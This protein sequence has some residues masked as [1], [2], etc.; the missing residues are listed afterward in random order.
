MFS[1]LFYLFF[2]NV[3]FGYKV[4]VDSQRWLAYGLWWEFVLAI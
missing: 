2:L 1:V 3:D 4:H